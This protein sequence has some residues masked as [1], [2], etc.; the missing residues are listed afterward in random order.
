LL[1]RLAG[2]G[3]E[4]QALGGV[5]AMVGHIWPVTLKFRG[6]RGVATGIGVLL[7]LDP[8]AGV[9][10]ALAFI[11]I[12]VVSRYVSLGSI[13]AGV[14]GIIVLY[15]RGAS[16]AELLVVA[17]GIALIIWRHAPNIARLRAGT[18]NRFSPRRSAPAR[19]T[20]P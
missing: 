8:V 4:W 19:A 13:L 17:A 14:P 6:G 9:V 20:R 2:G 12:V 3:P 15:L 5:L 16:T 7:T 1:V 11:L 18:E 10:A